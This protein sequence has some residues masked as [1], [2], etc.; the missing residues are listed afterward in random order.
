MTNSDPKG[1]V[2]LSY[3]HTNNGFFFCPPNRREGDILVLVWILSLSILS[4]FISVCYLWNEWMDFDQ[5][6]IDALL[7]EQKELIRFD[8]LDLIFKVTPA[9]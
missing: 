6:C 4:S 5:T 9:L 3:P 8:D 1:L 7:A 2:F